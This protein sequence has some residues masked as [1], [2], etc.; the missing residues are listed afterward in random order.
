MKRLL[1]RR[2]AWNTLAKDQNQNQTQSAGL[3]ASGALRVSAPQF[4]LNEYPVIINDRI[5]AGS[6]VLR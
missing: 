3:D 1:G 5:T 2:N 4:G 6:V